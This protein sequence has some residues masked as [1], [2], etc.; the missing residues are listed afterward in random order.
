[1]MGC[2]IEAESPVCAD[3][4]VCGTGLQRI[5]GTTVEQ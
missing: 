4:A 2:R 1:M 5:A 3:A